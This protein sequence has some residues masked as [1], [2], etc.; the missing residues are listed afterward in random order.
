MS[1]QIIFGTD[2]WRGVLGG[3]MTADSVSLVAQAFADYAQQRGMK[4]GIAI[5][6][7]GRAFSRGFAALFERILF[8]NGIH[9]VRSANVIPTPVLSWTVIT[10]GLDA[11]VM[12]TASHN[13]PSYNGVK[14]KAAYGG[15][16]VTEQTHAVEQLIGK[17]AVRLDEETRPGEDLLTPYFERLEQLVRFDIIKQAGIEMVV[18]SMHGAG[19]T[20]LETLLKRNGCAATTIAADV[21]TD[22]GGRLPE[23]IERNMKPLAEALRQNR[24]ASLGV[25]TDGDADRVGVMLEDGRWLSAQETILLL[26]DYIIRVRRA[27]GNIVKTSSVTDKV[28][29][30]YESDG[31]TVHDVQVGFKYI[32][33]KMTAEKIA[34]GCEESGGYGYGEHIPD[35]DGIVSALLLAELLAHSG[36]KKLSALVTAKRKA[37]G[38]LHYD[39]IDL[40]YHANDRAEILPRALRKPPWK[41]AGF[42]V[43]GVASF[44]SSRG[45]VNGLKIVCGGNSRWLLLRASETE[46]IIRIYA[47]GNSDEEVRGL[48]EAG[49]NIVVGEPVH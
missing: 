5:G 40:E 1:Q 22:F 18:D 10:R 32:A 16:F 26:T 37:F 39:R 27:P 11:G 13:P 3:D 36:H 46:P 49:R 23:P 30:L 29:I 38:Q 48:L 6:F 17:S 7:D 19:G 2:G 47:E 21:K 34:I 43:H 4:K 14:F 8:A 20:V 35:R 44:K 12:I 24:N 45:I 15:P 33:E 25:A 9:T 31:R 28:R 41:V 42:K